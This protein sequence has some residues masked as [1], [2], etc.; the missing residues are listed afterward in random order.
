MFPDWPE[1]SIWLDIWHLI[2]RLSVATQQ[3]PMHCMPLLC[4]GWTI[5]YTNG[6]SKI[7]AKKYKL[8]AMHV[9]NQ[10]DDVFCHIKSSELAMRCRRTTRGVEETTRLISQLI[11]SLDGDNGRAQRVPV[12]N[13]ERMAEIWKQQQKHVQ[14]IQDPPNVQLYTQTGVSKKG[15][16]P[17]PVYCISLCEGIYIFG[18]FPSALG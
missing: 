15:G 9:E 12:I 14:C 16:G 13:S 11:Q 5:A 4:L 18:M 2:R 6:I 7:A 17:L 8:E 1:L 10:T 3:M